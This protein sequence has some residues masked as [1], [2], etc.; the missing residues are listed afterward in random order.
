MRAHT[1]DRK[2][3]HVQRPGDL[4]SQWGGGRQRAGAEGSEVLGK[5][6]RGTRK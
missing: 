2:T 3:G 6:D 1:A 5:E 4:H